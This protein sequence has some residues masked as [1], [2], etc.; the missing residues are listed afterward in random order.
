MSGVVAAASAGEITS[1]A[2][3]LSSGDF[4][5]V[6]PERHKM[7]NEL[8]ISQRTCIAPCARRMS[9]GMTAGSAGLSGLEKRSAHS[10]WKR[11]GLPRKPRSEPIF[12]FDLLRRNAYFAS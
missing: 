2:G 3:E 4:A 1:C 10:S 12:G 9:K 5:D 11:A 6:A 7:P 8:E